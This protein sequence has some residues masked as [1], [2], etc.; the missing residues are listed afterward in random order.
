MYRISALL[1]SLRNSAFPHSSINQTSE[2]SRLT[3]ALEWRCDNEQHIYEIP[4]FAGWFEC[5]C[6]V[7]GSGEGNPTAVLVDSAA[8]LNKRW[9]KVSKAAQG[10]E[11]LTAEQRHALRKELK[12]LRY[13]VESFAPLFPSKRVDPFLK[14]LK[15]LQTI[16]VT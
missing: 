10:L 14:G 8:A 12:K 6:V 3:S 2:L 16:S 4:H 15:R 11:T 13:A 1:K 7:G 9:K 5:Q